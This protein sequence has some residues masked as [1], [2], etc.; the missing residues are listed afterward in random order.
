MKKLM[1]I[2]AICI[3][4]IGFSQSNMT[5]FNNGGQQFYVIL[6]GIKQNSKPMTNV[7]VGGIKNG[8]YSVKLIFADGKTPDI[9]KN[10]FVEEPSDITT[11]VVFKKGKGKLQLIGMEPTKGVSTQQE[12]IVYRPDNSAGF[13]D[14]LVVTETVK[15]ETVVN[16]GTQTQNT[17]ATITTNGN[18]QTMNQSTT[19][20][21][22]VNSNGNMGMN[23]N[24]NVNDP[25][26]G[27]QNVNMS[28]TLNG[29]GTQTTNTSTQTTQTTT[30][31]Q[32][33]TVNT[34]GNQTSTNTQ[35]SSASSSVVTCKNILGDGD[36]FARDLKALT[37][38][39]DRV[40]MIRKD[41]K[42]NCLTASQS[43][44]IIETL[45]FEEDRLELSKFLYDRMIDKD[46]GSVLLPLFT[47]D[48][49]KIEL[50]EYMNKKN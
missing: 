24:I 49:S 8:S 17:N 37:F 50:K 5:I 35:N 38:D 42:E 3:E 18:T 15:Q 45:T 40:A 6:N 34:S 14:A 48:S 20:T 26:N 22:P 43:Y 21:D 10:F 13:S 39:D 19:V 25:T 9:D 2:L 7:V 31:T 27:S 1:T 29:M 12:V 23:V 32:S 30:V 44:K 41:L 28:I 36:K 46:K 4:F 11:R 47:F 33:S 16:S